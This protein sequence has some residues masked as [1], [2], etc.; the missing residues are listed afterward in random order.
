MVFLPNNKGFHHDF[1]DILH[2]TKLLVQFYSE[3]GTFTHFGTFHPNL[4]MVILLDN[5]FCQ[6]QTQSPT[7]LLGG[8]TRAEDVGDVFFLDSLARVRHLDSDTLA[9]VVHE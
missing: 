5:A 8:E 9:L 1:R 7:T 2:T 3:R 4:P 6:R